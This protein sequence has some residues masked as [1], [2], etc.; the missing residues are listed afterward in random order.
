MTATQS[1]VLTTTTT[2]TEAAPSLWRAGAVAGGLAAAATMAVAAVAM[3]I[4]VPLEIAGEAIPLVGFGQL[5]LVCTLLG[6][7]IAKG[8]RRWAS[9]PSTTYV[10]ITVAL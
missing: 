7:L 6:V 1:P 2:D 4:D 9:T 5:T 8:V 3:A 10:R